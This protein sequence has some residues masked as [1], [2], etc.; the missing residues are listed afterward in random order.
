MLYGGQQ[1]G[2]VLPAAQIFARSTLRFQIH[3]QARL[4][5]CQRQNRSARTL[6]LSNES[7][8]EAEHSSAVSSKDRNSYDAFQ[9]SRRSPTWPTGSRRYHRVA[10]GSST[11]S[12]TYVSLGKVVSASHLQI[13][14]RYAST[15]IPSTT[16]FPAHPAEEGSSSSSTRIFN[17]D[18]GK[19]SSSS[20]QEDIIQASRHKAGK[21]KWK[22]R[23]FRFLQTLAAIALAGVIG[24]FFIPPVRRFI[25]T[26]KR[27]TIVAVAVGQCILDYKILFRKE[28]DDP[29]VRHN[30]YKA[31]HSKSSISTLLQLGANSNLMGCAI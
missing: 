8:H 23:R 5:H 11:S 18:R 13:R 19:K 2:A 27:C 21:M 22:R 4:L 3:V 7:S 31:C 10:A 26:I 25:I 6:G 12:R 15:A 17:N 24:Y 20:P 16:T 28:W 1:A 29:S 30:D 14:S 9:L